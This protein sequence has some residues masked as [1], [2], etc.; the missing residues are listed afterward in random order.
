LLMLSSRITPRGIY[1][2]LES[3]PLDETMIQSE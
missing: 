1:H 2:G 3:P